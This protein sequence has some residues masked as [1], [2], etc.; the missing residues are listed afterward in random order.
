MYYY[1]DLCPYDAHKGIFYSHI[2][3]KHLLHN[4][5]IYW[6]HLICSY[7]VLDLNLAHA[8]F[9]RQD[10]LSFPNE[11]RTDKRILRIV[12]FCES[13]HKDYKILR[14]FLSAERS[15]HIFVMILV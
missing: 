7:D 14:S 1:F 11:L 2:F 13:L 5:C 4:L 10:F 6:E 9:Q 3:H 15:L 8:Q 12:P